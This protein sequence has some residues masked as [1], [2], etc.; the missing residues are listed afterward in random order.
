MDGRPP[1]PTARRRRLR[2]LAAL[3]LCGAA[4]PAAGQS[5][6]DDFHV[7]G[8]HL[9]NVEGCTFDGVTSTVS[10][11]GAARLD[12]EGGFNIR[13]GQHLR[14]QFNN[15][16]GASAAV[17]N[18]D[19]SGRISTIA[20]ELSSNGRVML[21]NPANAIAITQGAN[22]EAAG[23]FL[24]STLEV[25]DEDAL[26]AGGTVEFSG[27]GGPQHRVTNGGTIRSA[28]G[29]ITLIGSSVTNL[30]SLTAPGGSV[31]LG[32]GTAIRYF[33]D[34]DSRIEVLDGDGANAITN[35]GR[36]TARDSVELA[37][38]ASAVDPGGTPRDSIDNAG[39]IRTT[40]P[41]GRVFLRSVDGG[42]IVNSADGT[43]DTDDLVVESVMPIAN[44]GEIVLP[45]DG[46]NPGAPSA[47]RQFPRLDSGQLA[48]APADDFRLSR[49]SF[50]HLNGLESK[51]K[52]NR[53]TVRASPR[54]A[55]T[56]AVRGGENA[57]RQPEPKRVI[58]RR[59]SFFGKKTS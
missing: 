24:A 48:A 59:G 51:A 14:F 20:G 52:A 11:N 8:A 2:L 54:P 32:A 1:P 19:G 33:G 36:I 25:A 12:W 56:V 6:C 45:D 40:A 41:G 7:P 13:P 55:G 34:G 47:A 57:G 53:P 37:T 46:S 18:R 9:G 3:T 38:T 15:A 26:L 27:G 4:A 35:T 31:H 29:D 23:G 58:L 17:L 30:G 28:Q 22:I 16:D 49:L 42:R 5:L 44:D 50:S 43:I 21:I 39:V 10:L